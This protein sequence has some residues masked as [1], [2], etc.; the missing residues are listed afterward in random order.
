[1]LANTQEVELMTLKD[2]KIMMSMEVVS[3]QNFKRWYHM[4][5]NNN[6]TYQANSIKEKELSAVVDI[7][8]WAI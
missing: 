8:E 6:N 7:K 5:T 2:T 1:M 4:E 3:C